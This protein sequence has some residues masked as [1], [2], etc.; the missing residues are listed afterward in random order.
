DGVGHERGAVDDR[1]EGGE[2]EAGRAQ[3]LFQALDGARRRVLGRGEAL[4]QA[5][6][7]GLAVDQDE[8]GERPA[9]G[10]AH[11]IAVSPSHPPSVALRMV[12]LL[13]HGR[14]AYPDPASEPLIG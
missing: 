10:D 13:D 6:A 12:R 7:P 1:A 4:V 5:D 2:P 14:N 9:D 3:E 11:A 8:V